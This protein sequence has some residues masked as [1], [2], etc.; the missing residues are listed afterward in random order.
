MPSEQTQ[1]RQ[2]VAAARQHEHP[3]VLSEDDIE[4]MPVPLRKL[5]E[6]SI[7][8]PANPNHASEE[9]RM[10]NRRRARMQ[11][12]F[13]DPSLM[14]AAK[15]Q[16]VPPPTLAAEIASSHNE[17]I[18]DDDSEQK[19]LDWVEETI[20]RLVKANPDEVLR[21]VASLT[22]SM[23][24]AN[25]WDAQFRAHVTRELGRLLKD[26]DV[27][28]SL[29]GTV[30]LSMNPTWNSGRAARAVGTILA[31]RAI[32]GWGH[33]E[34]LTTGDTTTCRKC[35]KSFMFPEER[36][37]HEKMCA[38]ATPKKTRK[39]RTKKVKPTELPTQT[40]QPV[41]A[42]QST[43]AEQSALDAVMASL[44]ASDGLEE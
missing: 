33:P 2:A 22:P 19:S 40:E 1:V 29:C 27:I 35:G 13:S 38:G 16:P 31:F 37:N 30:L 12:S 39:P 21:G 43:P 11:D 10:L 28:T 15:G 5:A 20:A 42:E 6:P 3:E 26:E 7:K 44:Q 4:V 9:E 32:Y 17:R 36:G 24:N 8:F 34:L 41:Q 18:F 23:F 14:P 25:R